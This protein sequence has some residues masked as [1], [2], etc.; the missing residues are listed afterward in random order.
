MKIYTS[1]W[2]RVRHFPLNLVGL[3]TT[4][5]PPRYRPLGKDSRGVW[6]LNC[7]PLVPG[8]ECNY[9]CRGACDPPHPENCAFLQTY[10]KQLDK[11]DFNE[12]YKYMKELSVKY[13]NADFAIIVFEP[14]TRKCSERLVIQQWFK[15]NGIEIEEWQPNT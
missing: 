9:L 11:I 4:V 3:N 14:P 13:D 2:A 5:W 15:N 6:V 12:F 8:A 1:Y 10:R 7:Q